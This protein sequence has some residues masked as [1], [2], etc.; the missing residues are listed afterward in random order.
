MP[1]RTTRGLTFGAAIDYLTGYLMAFGAMVALRRRAT[2]GGSWLVRLSLAQI[3]RW[4]Q[5]QGELGS[6]A[7]AEAAS[8]FDPSD[9]TTNRSARRYLRLPAK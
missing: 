8:D 2:T 7:L 1:T 6:A 4:L 9:R 3:G 5:Q